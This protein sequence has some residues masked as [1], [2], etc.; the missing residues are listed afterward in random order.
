MSVTNLLPSQGID[1]VN[2][3]LLSITP[4]MVSPQSYKA[5]TQ[6]AVIKRIEFDD[7]IPANT[8]LA[9]GKTLDVRLFKTTRPPAAQRLSDITIAFYGKWPPGYLRG[10]RPTGRHLLVVE[11][12]G[13]GVARAEALFELIFSI[14]Q[15]EPVF[16]LTK[17]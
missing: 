16:T 17:N 15:A 3:R 2:F 8:T 6:D 10:F 7:D 12:T 1:L 11:V 14:D 5:P 4:P 13:N 9:P